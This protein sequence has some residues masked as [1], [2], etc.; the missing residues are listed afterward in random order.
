MEFYEKDVYHF[1]Y[2]IFEF[3]HVLLY[4]A[5]PQHT[6]LCSRRQDFLTQWLIKT[7]KLRTRKNFKESFLMIVTDGRESLALTK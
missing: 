3:Y 6:K 5:S 4:H 1:L 7:D 2:F